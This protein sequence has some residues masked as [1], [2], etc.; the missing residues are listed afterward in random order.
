M[1]NKT[2]VKLS[3]LTL[4]IMITAFTAQP[5]IANEDAHHGAEE[6]DVAHYEL[7]MG[8]F[9]FQVEGQAPGEPL[10]VHAGQ[11]VKLEIKNEG[12]IFHEAMFGVEVN[13]DHGYVEDFFEGVG[14]KIEHEMVLGDTHRAFG[15]GIEGFEEVELDPEVS[16][17]I[18]FTVPASYAG[19]AFEIGCFVPGHYDAGMKIA[20]IVEEALEI[21][22]GHGV[23]EAGH[24][25]EILDTDN[26]GIV[27]TEDYCP[28]FPGEKLTNGC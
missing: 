4:V 2:R 3:L 1:Y 7:I 5:L 24:G 15:M 25:E 6:R 10:V 27:D 8:E 21:D 17:S 19:R 11:R 16:V 12:A 22:E 20:L 28:A 26:D 18:E 23:E 13:G 9:F 14:V